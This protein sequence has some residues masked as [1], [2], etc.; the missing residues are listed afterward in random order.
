MEGN[1]KDFHLNNF[2]ARLARIDSIL[3]TNKKKYTKHMKQAC[4]GK[5]REQKVR[6]STVLNTS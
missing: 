5:H 3:K 1:K 6:E 4:S 2:K